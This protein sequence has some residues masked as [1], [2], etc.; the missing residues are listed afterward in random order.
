MKG[1]SVVLL[2]LM[3]TSASSS[4]A[5]QGYYAF[6]DWGIFSFGNA[7]VDTSDGIRIGGGYNF[8]SYVG[9]EAGLTIVG[10]QN[11][12]SNSI[13]FSPYTDQSLNASTEHIAVVGTIPLEHH[14]DLV[15]KLGWATTT[16]DYQYSL[17]GSGVQSV[18]GSG[19]AT[20]TNP[21]FGIGWQS[22]PDQQ[23][24]FY[25]QYENFG[26]ARMTVIYSN[27]TSSTH[28]VSVALISVGILHYF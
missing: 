20:K 5:D 27:Q 3:A 17:Y 4:A 19:S 8:N 10:W 1:L 23:T 28:D 15:A 12:N 2:L 6:G 9:A 26:K 7:P 24:R 11:R 14:R 21:M 18:S 13:Q 16:L 25:V 22:A